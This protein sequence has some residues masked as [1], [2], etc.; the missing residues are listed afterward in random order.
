MV[1]QISHDLRTP[2]N[3]IVINLNT[4]LRDMPETEEMKEIKEGY[5][6]PALMNCDQLTYLIN[7]VLTFTKAGFN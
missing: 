3:G 4:A 7:D 2:L 1:G 6:E 5:L